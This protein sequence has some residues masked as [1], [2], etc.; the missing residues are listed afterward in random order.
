MQL[1]FFKKYENSVFFYNLKSKY[2]VHLLN[3]NNEVIVHFK[4][5]K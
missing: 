5:F 2:D 3:N 4:D 1:Y